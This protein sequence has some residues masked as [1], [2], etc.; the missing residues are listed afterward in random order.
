[1][2]S[3]RVSEFR[4]IQY[5]EC[6]VKWSLF[7]FLFLSPEQISQLCVCGLQVTENKIV[8]MFSS[9]GF[10]WMCRFH[11]R[12]VRGMYEEK[13]APQIDKQVTKFTMIL[14]CSCLLHLYHLTLL[15]LYGNIKSYVSVS[16]I[17]FH[18]YPNPSLNLAHSCH[19]VWLV[20]LGSCVM[21]FRLRN[22]VL[23]SHCMDD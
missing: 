15:F 22:K 13:K 4:Y 21:S 14:H 3:Y 7:Q 20:G 23:L 18:C 6:L 8:D 12:L 11:I 16:C 1:M 10:V 5:R 17:F 19:L 2:R 9:A